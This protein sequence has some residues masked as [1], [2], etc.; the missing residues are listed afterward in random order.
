MS[1]GVGVPTAVPVVWSSKPT[2]PTSAA[3]NAR[4][5]ATTTRRLSPSSPSRVGQRRLAVVRSSLSAR[6]LAVLRTVAAHRY[7][8][9]RQVEGFHFADHA[10]SL[11]GARVARRVLRRL[12]DQRVLATIE[13]RI[14]GIRAGSAS[15]VWTVGTVG[16]RLLRDKAG[17]IRI[18]QREPGLLFL[19]HSLA[20][21]DAHLDLVCADREGEL[22]VVEVQCEPACWRPFT[23]LGGGRL[24]L[25]PD[26][27]VVS[28]D[29]AD[30]DF[31]N[32][33]FI[34][35][36]RGTENP[37]RLLAKCRHYEA[38]RRT[39][40]EQQTCGSFPLVVWVLHSEQR[41][42][43]LLAAIERDADVDT[44]LYRVTTQTAFLETVKAGPA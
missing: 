5:R 18:R 41:M 40:T 1:E 11:T 43:Q 33:W 13:R 19:D 14:G 34:E 16:D 23:G 28:G 10:S 30:P 7:L 42:A 20:V 15:Y 22:E 32:K 44:S 4:T 8:T 17:G 21:A 6:D 36:D 3:T 12:S 24:V 31:V 37:A 26:L 27:Y 2:S 25:Q 35:I 38:Y 39:G 29:P 9:T